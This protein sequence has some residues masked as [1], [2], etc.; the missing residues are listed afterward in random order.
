[1]S[2]DAGNLIL[3]VKAS[4]LQSSRATTD[5]REAAARIAP[6]LDF[7][8]MWP[9]ARMKALEKTS[10]AHG[11]AHEFLRDWPTPKCA[12]IYSRLATILL[13]SSQVLFE[14]LRI[15]D[16]A[17]FS[18]FEKK[19]GAVASELNLQRR[20][21]FRELHWVPL[22]SLLFFLDKPVTWF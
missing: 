6:K 9:A 21:H 4:S 13:V 15:N 8:H 17:R 2:R 11:P 5:V 20:P 18:G 14:L 19:N 1:M 10:G 12:E 3:R 7:P 22:E 16:D